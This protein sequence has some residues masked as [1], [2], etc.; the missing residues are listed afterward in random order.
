[1]WASISRNSVYAVVLESG[2][3]VRAFTVV[4]VGDAYDVLEVTE[5]SA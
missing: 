1:M 2:G 3:R 5:P 4:A